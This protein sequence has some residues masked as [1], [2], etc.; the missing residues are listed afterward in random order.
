MRPVKAVVGPEAEGEAALSLEVVKE[1]VVGTGAE[2][3]P[4]V[5]SEAVAE[6]LWW[7][8]C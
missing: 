8:P 1:E 3:E 2:T 5:L 6:G 4:V 7:R